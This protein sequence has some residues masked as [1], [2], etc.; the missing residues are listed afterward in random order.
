MLLAMT[1]CSLL[2]AN[3]M[4]MQS[5]QQ[6]VNA[7]NSVNNRQGGGKQQMRERFENRKHDILERIHQ[8]EEC[9]QR[10]ESPQELKAC[11]QQKSQ[12]EHH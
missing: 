12:G 9:V 10:A 8:R 4:N 7:G 6:N 5:S 2:F 1:S 11:M 3:D